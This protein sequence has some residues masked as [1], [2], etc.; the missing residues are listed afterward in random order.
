[1]RRKPSLDSP[2]VHAAVGRGLGGKGRGGLAG[3]DFTPSPTLARSPA[4][5]EGFRY[6]AVPRLS[7]TNKRPCFT[8]LNKVLYVFGFDIS[9]LG[10]MHNREKG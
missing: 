2:S 10:K 1:V 7:L 8:T 4:M 3:G 6:K 5:H 9:V